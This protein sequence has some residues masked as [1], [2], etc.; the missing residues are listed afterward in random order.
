MFRSI[1]WRI[2]VPFILL[3]LFI[4]LAVSF[5]LSNSMRQLYLDDL[6]NQLTDECALVT[7]I[8]QPVLSQGDSTQL[9]P[10]GD[11]CERHSTR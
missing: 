9:A 10:Y 2:A 8:I 1:R 7:D 4:M 6:R 3:A 11:C 5:Y